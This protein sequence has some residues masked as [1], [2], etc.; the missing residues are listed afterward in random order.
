MKCCCVR[1]RRDSVEVDTV[2]FDGAVP[3][4]D[5]GGSSKYSNENFEDRL[6]RNVTS[7]PLF[8]NAQQQTFDSTDVTHSCV[9]TES[10]TGFYGTQIP[11]HNV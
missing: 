7:P 2:R 5:L 4:A 11:S 3:S 6:G 1:G 8:A 9:M 10:I